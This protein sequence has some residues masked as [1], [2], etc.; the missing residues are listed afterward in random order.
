MQILKGTEMK[1]LENNEKN[2]VDF[3]ELNPGDCFRLEG[4]LYVKSAYGQEAVGLDD[5]HAL[6]GMCGDMVTPVNAQVQ[7]ID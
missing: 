1:V 5:G 3:A 7:I 2:T 6:C 4:Y